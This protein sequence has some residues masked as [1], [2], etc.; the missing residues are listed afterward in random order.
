MPMRFSACSQERGHVFVTTEHPDCDSDASN[1]RRHDAESLL[2]ARVSVV[3]FGGAMDRRLI[4]RE[5]RRLNQLCVGWSLGQSLFGIGL[6]KESVTRPGNRSCSVAYRAAVWA[7][8]IL[9]AN[10]ALLTRSEEHT[11]EL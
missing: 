7:I 4:W 2:F 11:S 5:A 10:C 8:Q 1:E 3:S 9:L 6:R